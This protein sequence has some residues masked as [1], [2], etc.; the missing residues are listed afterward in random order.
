MKTGHTSTL[1]TILVEYH[2]CNL[3]RNGTVVKN[4]PA[5]AGEVRDSGSSLGSG[6]SLEKEMATHSSILSWRIPWTEEP[7]GLHSIGSQRFRHEWSNLA[8]MHLIFYPAPGRAPK[9]LGI[10]CHRSNKAIFCDVSEVTFGK[11]LGSL[12]MVT[13]CQGNQTPDER[14]GTWGTSTPNLQGGKTAGDWTIANDE[15]FNQSGLCHVML[16]FSL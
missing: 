8:R 5:N 2:D 6:R 7:G 16:L 11:P 4:S 12:R 3:E 10:Y 1:K 9:T 13:G 15:W 14:V